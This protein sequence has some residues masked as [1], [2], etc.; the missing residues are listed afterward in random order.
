M[1]ETFR[2]LRGRDFRIY[3][4]GQV[5]SLIGTWVQQVAMSWITYRVTGS[6]FMLGLIA[7]S[8]QIPMLLV[9]PVGGALAD[10]LER[11]DILLFTQVAAMAVAAWLAFV[12]YTESFSPAI[13][14][15]SSILMGVT[16]GLE[17]P[18]RQAFLMEIVHDQSHRTNAIALNSLT[19]NGARLVGPAAS[20]AILYLLSETACFVINAVSFLAAIYTLLVIRPRRAERRRPG[21][22]WGGLS[23]LREFAPARWLLGT[24][25]ATSLC[26]SPFMTF[27]PVYAKDVFRGG[28]DALG[29][30]MGASGLGAVL[31][32]VFLAT[33]E[34]LAGSGA[35]IAGA[36]FA[37]GLA[38][39]AFA[40]NPFLW[41]ALPILMVSGGAT[42]MVVT[43]CNMLLQHLVPESLRG[44]VMALYTMSFVGMMPVGSLLTGALAH[45]V[46][47]HLVFVL[48]GMVAVATGYAVTRALPALR[49]Q[50]K[51]VLEERNF[52]GKEAHGE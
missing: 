20:G 21:A 36:C 7:F 1:K 19:F 40:Y 12:S 37:C 11:R 14:V 17:M 25:A 38:S 44:R 42:I 39:M 22:A 51:P 5:V 24:V 52:A 48:S 29:L 32:S 6:A 3:F 34:S 10:R 46:G 23:Y 9:S 31:V 43:S 35:R 30:L 4:A 2:A 13:L 15:V 49:A 26:I 50:A 28:P 8:G 41:S 45:V 18:T 47:V 16:G 27:M 33:R